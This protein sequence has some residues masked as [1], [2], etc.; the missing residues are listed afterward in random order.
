[1]PRIL[2]TAFEPYPPWPTNASWLALIELTRELPADIE[3]TTRLYPVE[4]QAMQ[5]KLATDLKSNFDFAF[6]LGQ[7]PGSCCI[8]L[9]EF[10]VNAAIKGHSLHDQHLSQ[11][12]CKAGPAAYRSVLPLSE[13]ASKLRETGIPARVSF[14]AGTFL[15]N[16]NFYWSCRLC[17]DLQLPTKSAFIHVPLETSQ[18]VKLDEPQ[19]FMPSSMVSAGLKLLME[20]ATND[21]VA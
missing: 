5:E 12:V 4:L 17:E 15:C 1:M 18:V 13:Y 9:E 3:I 8:Q 19:P 11:K 6:H 14:H 21:S 20:L 7:A 10:A 16:A 2:L